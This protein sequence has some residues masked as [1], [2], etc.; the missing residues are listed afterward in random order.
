MLTP[1]ARKRRK[2]ARLA[3]LSARKMDSVISSSRRAAGSPVLASVA[4]NHLRQ[5]AFLE[6]NRRKIHRDFQIVRPCRRLGAGLMQHPF[7]N[8][9]NQ[10]DLLGERK[11]PC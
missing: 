5:V 8:R 3:L 7:T 2:V 6:L 4:K 1:S 10:T 11:P 9:D